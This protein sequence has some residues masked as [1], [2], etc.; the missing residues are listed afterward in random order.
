MPPLD[1][2]SD[3]QAQLDE[4]Q[5]LLDEITARGADSDRALDIAFNMLGIFEAIGFLVTVGGGLLAAF[6]VLRLFSAQAELQKARERFEQ[7]IETKERELDEMKESLEAT[8]ANS[9]SLQHR[10]LSQAT[11]AL[12]LLPLGERQ[13]RAQDFQGAMDTYRRA[14]ELDDQNPV[15]HL[16]L[17]YVCTQSGLL[18][19]ARFHLTRALDIEPDFAAALAALGYVYRRIA[20]KMEP[21][22]ERESMLNQAEGKLLEALNKSPKL[23]DDDGESWWGSLGGLYRRR[24]QIEDAIRAY[25]RAAEVTPHSSYP[26]SNLAL[27]YMQTSNRDQMLAT[28]RRVERLAR[29]ETQADVDNYWAHADLL[30]SQLAL[31]KVNQAEESLQS[32]LDVAPVDSPYVL[33]L[34]AD[35]L[36]RLTEALGGSRA[37]PHIAPFIERVRAEIVRRRNGQN[38]E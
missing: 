9:A 30:T 5:R 17:G 20:E 23:V 11:L 37:V 6:G 2:T 16:R 31:G 28:Y 13:Y 32:V 12:S 1:Q 7:E 3:L 4:A 24:N 29:G 26:F 25:E 35:T 8:I 21:T 38:G 36:G 22:V 27:L 10:E 18:D 14:L 15:T 19:E 33:E 34:L